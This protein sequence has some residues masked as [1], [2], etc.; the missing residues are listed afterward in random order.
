[1]AARGYVHPCFVSI[2]EDL[3][4]RGRI[5]PGERGSHGQYLQH[6]YCVLAPGFVSVYLVAWSMPLT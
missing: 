2:A 6:C 4:R 3:N 1:M 5:Y